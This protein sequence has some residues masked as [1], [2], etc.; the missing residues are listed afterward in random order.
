MDLGW[1][2]Q[3][4]AFALVLFGIAALEAVP[5]WG[6]SVPGHLGIATMTAVAVATEAASPWLLVAATL[7]AIL[8]DL[9]AFAWIRLRP[10]HGV[11]RGGA[12]WRAGLD[13]DDLS[14]QLHKTPFLTFLRAKFSTKERARLPYASAKAGMSGTGFAILSTMGS[15]L[16]APTWVLLGGAVGGATLFLPSE[17]DF[18]IL[19]VGLVTLSTLVSRPNQAP[20]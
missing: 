4:L 20:H 15:A 14:D 17:G 5:P 13:V 2:Q 1:S 12:W 8:S 11:W 19:A 16:W 18:V 7:G 9:A 10:F 3:I 6:R